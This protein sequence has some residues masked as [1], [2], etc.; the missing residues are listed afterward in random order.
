MHYGIKGKLPTPLIFK[1]LHMVLL[2]TLF[3]SLPFQ[4]SVLALN[5]PEDYPYSQLFFYM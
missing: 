1:A 4:N 2:I 3:E 5:K